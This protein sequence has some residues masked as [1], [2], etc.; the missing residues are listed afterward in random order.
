MAGCNTYIDV[1][2]DYQAVDKAAEEFMEKAEEI[3]EKFQNGE[4]NTGYHVI[5]N[6]D[7]KDDEFTFHEKLVSY[8]AHNKHAIAEALTTFCYQY[9]LKK[10]FGRL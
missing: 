6:G 2:L 3:L 1:S 9:G 4:E 7:M 8:V 5:E 10:S